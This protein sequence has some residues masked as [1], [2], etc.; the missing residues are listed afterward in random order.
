MRHLRYTVITV[1]SFLM[2]IANASKITPTEGQAIYKS[3]STV[4]D[5][6]VVAPPNQA[7]ISVNYFS[8]F[9]VDDKALK[10]VNS[11]VNRGDGYDDAAMLV[12]IIADDISISN[13]VELLGPASDI[14]FL[15]RA[16][17][18]L[19]AC[20][21]C[22]FENFYRITL[23]VAETE[24]TFPTSTGLIGQLSTTASGMVSINNLFA[25]G[26]LAVETFANSVSLDGLIDTHDRADAEGLAN[27]NG[28]SQSQNGKFTIGTGSVNL[29]MG[30]MEWDYDS[31]TIKSVRSSDVEKIL[32]GTIKSVEV[33]ITSS[34]S[35]RLNTNI[36]TR[37]DLLS[38]TQYKGAA[39]L[40]VEGVLVLDFGSG[41]SGIGRQVYSNGKFQFSSNGSLN[42][43]SEELDVSSD[44]LEFIAN[45]TFFNESGIQSRVIKI[46]AK[47]FINR[48]SIKGEDSVEIWSR[49]YLFNEFGGEILSRSLLLQ[50]GLMVRNGSRFPYYTDLSESGR[51]LYLSK[52]L[53]TLDSS[54]CQYLCDEIR[55]KKVSYILS[56]SSITDGLFYDINLAKDND[57]G[58]EKASD[59]GAK[60]IGDI[61]KIKSKNFENINPYWV[62]VPEKGGVELN[63]SLVSQVKL[64][65]ESELV[66]RL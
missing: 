17:R 55:E 1:L 6:L 22:S 29:M 59:T 3:P 58:R 13:Q 15:S 50:A 27:I 49:T 2:S 36:D 4:E 47:N 9:V 66:M 52:S 7:G 16:D 42:I 37:T 25:R 26:A 30:Q 8:E 40:P 10:L 46:A 19:V 31:Q 64:S 65:A 14:L 34:D 57:D 39:Y 11:P 12:V 51:E 41:I 32:N 48:G 61:V 44:S 56:P 33:K 62:F 5:V 60:V 54:Y 21:G 35:L 20:N 43:V 24:S 38:T 63:R 53:R 45:K 23:A 28:Y 18:G